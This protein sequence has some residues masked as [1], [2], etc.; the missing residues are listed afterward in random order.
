MKRI[1]NKVLATKSERKRQLKRPKF[2]CGYK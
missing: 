1:E 2:R